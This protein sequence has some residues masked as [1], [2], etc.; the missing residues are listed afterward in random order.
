M[1]NDSAEIGI[2][3]PIIEDVQSGDTFGNRMQNCYEHFLDEVK[4][5]FCFGRYNF[6]H[7]SVEDQLRCEYTYY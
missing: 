7:V 6:Q 5:I 4:R 2:T 1:P 3:D